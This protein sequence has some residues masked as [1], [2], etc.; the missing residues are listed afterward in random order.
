MTNSNCWICSKPAT[1]AEHKTKRSDLKLMSQGVS[2][3]K[4]DRLIKT[5]NNGKES[6]I[7]GLDSQA[8]KYKKNLCENC[9]S[10]KSQPWD[11]AYEML[12][13]F[14]HQNYLAIAR[15]R[16]INLK[17][18]YGANVRNAQMNLFKYFAKA[19]GCAINE[20]NDKVPSVIF[21]VINGK[22]FDGRSFF[23]TI[24][25]CEELLKKNPM[26][27]VFTGCSDLETLDEKK[28]GK[29]VGYYRWAQNLGWLVIAYSYN[30]EN[31][32]GG[33]PWS[34]KSKSIEF[35]NF[36]ILKICP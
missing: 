4:G 11:K 36:S 32:D 15:D 30:L 12:I 21:D 14:V 25:V 29:S 13:S 34:G 19:F 16:K 28:S 31:I 2:F 7:Q 26:L 35:S 18:V 23:I 22:S 5:L 27:S 8:L 6:L 3:K 10:A 9:N 17:L 20:I 1:T 33:I 24:S